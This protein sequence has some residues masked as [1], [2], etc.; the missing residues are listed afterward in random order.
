MPVWECPVWTNTRKGNFVEMS[1]SS[2]NRNVKESKTFV[3]RV[4]DDRR[5]GGTRP[6]MFFQ[7]F[8][9]L[10]LLIHVLTSHNF[11]VRSV[12]WSPDGKQIASGSDDDTIKIW[13]SQSGDCQST[14]T[15]HLGQYVFFSKFFFPSSFS[16]HGSVD[17]CPDFL[18]FQD[19]LC[20][21]EPRWKE[22]CQRQLWQNHQDLGLAIWRLRVD[23]D[24]P[25]ATVSFLINMLEQ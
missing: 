2:K 14:L 7:N 15:G 1:M 20:G 21:V 18:Q 13:D 5:W 12:A 23:A 19:L 4:D 6:G 24:R 17:S 3:L 8:P 11:R 25:L 9:S 22:N 10:L 16:L